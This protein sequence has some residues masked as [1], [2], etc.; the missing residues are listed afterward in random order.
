WGLGPAWGVAALAGIVWWLTARAR[1]LEGRVW[2]EGTVLAWGLLLFAYHA[3]Q[4]VTTGRYFLPIVP[5]LAVFA[6]WP[7]A[8]RPTPARSA[9]AAGLIAL[10]AAWAVAFTAIYRR[11]ISRVEASRWIYRN[12]PAGA[13]IANEHWD[14]GLPLAVDDFPRGSYRGIE[15]HLYDED[16]V[17]KR[18]TLIDQLAQADYVILSSNRLYRSIPRTPWRY[19]L[20]RRYYELLFSGALGFRLERSF[21]SYPRLGALEIPDDEAEEAFTVYDHPHVLIFKKTSAFDRGAVERLL[22]AVPLSGIVHVAPR[23]ASALY[24]QARPTDI[25]LPRSDGVRTAVAQSEP[26]SLGALPGGA[27]AVPFGSFREPRGVAR[28]PDGTF[29]V[30]DFGYQ[31]VQHVDALRRSHGGF[32]SEGGG[33]GQFHDPCGVAVGDDG[34]VYVADTWNHRVQKLSAKGEP[35]AEWEAGFYGPRGIALDPRGRIY[36]ADTGKHRVVRLSR[37]GSVE[38]EW[39]R[40]GDVL[41]APVGIAISAGREVY[42][43]D[44]D[45]QRVVVFSEDGQLRRQWPIDGRG[46]GPLREPYLAI[47]RDGTVWVTDPSSDRVLLFDPRGRPLG[48]ARPLAP[49]SAPTGIALIDDAHAIVANTGAHSLAVVSRTAN[50]SVDPD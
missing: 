9:V 40:K 15:L 28:A 23:R 10:T 20:T 37:G 22:D 2:L 43:A 25:P 36:V 11:P 17:S 44:G 49:L 14:D 39:G 1:R 30:A 45:R 19:P 33:P 38:R 12:V 3:T 21:T 41:S 5:V 32:G 42:V 24:R 16:T 7:L 35:I 29:Y 27:S 34:D 8:A 26:T 46:S 13:T 4:F 48:T 50:T 6:V 18:S 31:R 47:G